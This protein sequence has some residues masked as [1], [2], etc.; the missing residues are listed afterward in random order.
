MFQ[1]KSTMHSGFF[2]ARLFN[3]IV[4]LS[5]IAALLGVTPLSAAPITPATMAVGDSQ[6]PVV[7]RVNAGGDPYTDSVG[8]T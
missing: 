2:T 3:Q 5:F 8:N 6:D 1:G 7:I 4:V